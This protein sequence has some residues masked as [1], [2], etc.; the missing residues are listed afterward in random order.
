VPVIAAA[1]L[2][3]T[4]VPQREVESGYAEMSAEWS[5]LLGWCC[6]KAFCNLDQVNSMYR[7]Q[8]NLFYVLVQ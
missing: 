8:V 7:E 5:N 4:G 6:D 1:S 3:V 2:Q